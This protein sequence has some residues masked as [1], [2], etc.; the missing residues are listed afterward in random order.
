MVR[1]RA[2]TAIPSVDPGVA[3]GPS[4]GKKVAHVGIGET[5]GELIEHIA[6]V[7]PQVEAEP[8]HAAAHAQEHRGGLHPAVTTSVQ[9]VRAPHGE[10]T[11]GAFGLAVVDREPRF[12]E[13]PNERS[14]LIPGMVDGLTEQ[15][16]RRCLATLHF[17]AFGKRGQDRPGPRS[18]H[19]RHLGPSELVAGLLPVFL[20]LALDGVERADEG[21]GLDRPRVAQLGLHEIATGVY[22]ATQL[23]NVAVYRV[24]AVVGVGVDEDAVAREERSWER[25]APAGGEV[26][27]GVGIQSIAEVHP[28]AGGP[29]RPQKHRGCVGGMDGERTPLPA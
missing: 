16:L 1:P 21:Q 29:P 22:P 12:V 23:S 11:D 15:A 17:E 19:P 2:G 10:R 3:D 4:I 6:D 24:V 9:P 27:Q 26:A 13:V 20:D 7:R 28:S 18:S 5:R 14:P 25:L 8:R